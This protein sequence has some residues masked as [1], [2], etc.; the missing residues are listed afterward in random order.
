[1]KLVER[2]VDGSEDFSTLPQKGGASRR[3]PVKKQYLFTEEVSS[4]EEALDREGAPALYSFFLRRT[5]SKVVA[6]GYSL[7][8][9]IGVSHL[10][11]GA[12]EPAGIFFSFSMTLSFP[13]L[14]VHSQILLRVGLG[15]RPFV[16]F[17]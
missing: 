4:L 9:I 15:S 1:L 8:A 17:F 6:V 16:S 2:L 11:I 10:S 3:R 5:V 13:P 7:Y 12:L 14:P